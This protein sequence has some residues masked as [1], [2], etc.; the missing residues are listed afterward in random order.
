MLLT[1]LFQ[2]KRKESSIVNADLVSEVSVLTRTSRRF[3]EE[4]GTSS[5]SFNRSRC[6]C[7][8]QAEAR[9]TFPT[10][11]LRHRENILSS[12]TALGTKKH[13]HSSPSSPDPLDETP[14]K[15]FAFPT[16]NGCFKIIP[17]FGEFGD[18][19]QR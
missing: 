18:F 6:G 14:G 13:P 2:Y 7:H 1:A 3:H 17:N 8:G 15:V 4:D 16:E 9:F 12:L 5:P 19:F 11:K 10:G